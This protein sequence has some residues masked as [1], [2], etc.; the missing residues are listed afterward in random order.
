MSAKKTQVTTLE[1]SENTLLRVLGGPHAKHFAR[2][3]T[4]ERRNYV[5]NLKRTIIL[6]YM[7]TRRRSR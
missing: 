4:E 6:P 3:E 1:F 7:I 5:D 2:L